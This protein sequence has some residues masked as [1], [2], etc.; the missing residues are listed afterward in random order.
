MK[1]MTNDDILNEMRNQDINDGEFAHKVYGSNNNV[2]AN[3]RYVIQVSWQHAMNTNMRYVYSNFLP[4][5]PIV[6]QKYYIANLK[7][8]HRYC[9]KKFNKELI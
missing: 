7:D 8:I 9:V 5:S 1:R 2:L 3:R 6:E 4:A